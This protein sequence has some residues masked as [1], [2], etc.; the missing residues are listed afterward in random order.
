MNVFRKH[1]VS[2]AL[3]CIGLS[4]DAIQSTKA[5]VDPPKTTRILYDANQIK[6]GQTISEVI[7]ILGRPTSVMNFDAKKVFDYPD[8]E[9]TF[10]SE[11]VNSI[12]RLT[13]ANVLVLQH[14]PVPTQ[15]SATQSVQTNSAEKFGTSDNSNESE[16]HV[17]TSA[18]LGFQNGGN[19]DIRNSAPNAVT[20][21]KVG[22][23]I[24]A[25][26]P[27]KSVEAEFTEEARRA[28]YQGVCLLT[29]IVDVTGKPQ[30]VRVIRP[31][32][33]GLDANALRAVRKYRFKPAMKNGQ[34]P[35]PVKMTIEVNF[36]LRP[37]NR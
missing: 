23:E 25:P 7:A 3:I 28:G 33:M 26:I 17:S 6:I 29:L 2:V 8:V 4:L 30:D 9:I 10:V 20:L 12:R 19:T 32:G 34:T 13:S 27:V 15:P 37:P 22:G 24:S 21:Y 31:L 16:T 5:Q 35:V 14:S 18:G 11:K 1:G 36:R